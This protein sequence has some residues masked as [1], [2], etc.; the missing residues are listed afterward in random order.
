MKLYPATVRIIPSNGNITLDKVYD[1]Y[2][3]GD[4]AEIGFRFVVKADVEGMEMKVL[5]GA[6]TLLKSDTVSFLICTYHK[7]ENEE[8]IENLLGGYI[9]VTGE[10]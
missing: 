10:I 2:M 5:A 1:R 9:G 3:N 7:P 6:K 4:N 8:E